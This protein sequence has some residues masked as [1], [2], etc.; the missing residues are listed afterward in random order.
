MV[1]IR[2]PTEQ[3]NQTGGSSHHGNAACWRW[4]MSWPADPP[5]FLFGLP[6]AR[7]GRQVGG[8]PVAEHGAIAQ[9]VHDHEGA[10]QRVHPVAHEQTV[11]T[12]AHHFG[13]H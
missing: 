12:T 1:S 8:A 2:A 4:P 11:W 9:R 5:P 7:P 10:G 13:R 3:K 6:S